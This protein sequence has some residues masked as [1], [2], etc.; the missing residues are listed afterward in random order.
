[1]IVRDEEGVLDACLASI[2]D[3]VD[4]IVIADTGS[5]DRSLEIGRAYGARVIEQPWQG[6][7][8]AARNAALAAASGDWILYID[9]DERLAPVARSAV[10]AALDRPDLVAGLLWFRAKAGLTPYREYR[11]FRNDPRIRFRGVM[12]ETMLPDILQVAEQDGLEVGEVEMLIEHIGYDGPQDRKHRRNLP[13]L[14]AGLEER[15][16]N[17]YLW[18]HLGMVLEALGDQPA[19]REAWQQAVAATRRVGVR[20]GSDCFA[21]AELIRTDLADLTAARRLHA[22]ALALFGENPLL[23]YWGARIEAAAGAHGAAIAGFQRLTAIDAE[24]FRD[25]RMGFD[26]R[27]FGEFAWAWLG[28]C[29]FELGDYAESARWFARAAAANPESLEYLAKQQLA[30]G[31]AGARS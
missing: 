14:R 29:S 5:I 10:A 28:T 22:E 21:Y 15:P 31:R 30:Q 17:A 26:K 3:V 13:L 11:L 16:A 27:L 6:D 9:A 19:A 8:S 23:I 25:R 4:E 12:H 20:R 7:F 1:M 24:A 18:N 2:K